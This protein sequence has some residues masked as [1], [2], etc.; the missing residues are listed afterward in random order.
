M[1]SLASESNPF[2][3]RNSRLIQEGRTDEPF[4]IQIAVG[5]ILSLIRLFIKQGLI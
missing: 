3:S 1:E 5:L 2:Q 4:Q